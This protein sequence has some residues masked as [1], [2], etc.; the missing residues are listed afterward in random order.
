MEN[1][2]LTALRR[3]DMVRPGDTVICAVSGG[4]DSMA[5]LWGMWLLKEKLGITVEAAHFNHNLRGEESR[6]DAE[7]VRS[8]CDFHEI[9]L[10]MGSG[11]VIPGPKGLE[12]AARDARYAFLRSLDGII[13]TAHT[14]DDNAETVLMHLLRGTGLRG[15]GGVTPKQGTLI[16][17]MLD[18]TRAEVEAFLNENYIRHVE[19]SSNG[20]DA[21][22]R[23]RL[24]HHVMP[25][26]KA[27][28]PSIATGLSAAAQR[29]REDALLLDE[30]ASE[31]D[32]TDVNALRA[33]PAP[34]RRRAIENL[35]KK[36]GFPEPSAGHIAQAEGVVFS[37]NP[38][39]RT[40]FGGLTLRRSY[41]KL[42]VDREQTVLQTRVL[43]REGVTAL[44]E[45]G[46]AVKTAVADGPGE[47]VVSPEG[48][49]VVRG[50]RPGDALTTKGGTKSLKKRFIDRKIPQWE[51]LAVPVVAD[52][53][54]VLA[55]MGF[56]VDET[57]R[58][59]GSYVRIEFVDI[60]ETAEE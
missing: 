31:L 39:A 7:F 29:I 4:V 48:E 52:S 35:L 43:P 44:P 30:L 53:R 59:G 19:D 26:L 21:F 32:A 2:L 25:L 8:F 18:V 56:G 47:N 6:R 50:R 16:R 13:A 10:H 14:A 9:P 27:E 49:M 38:S 45:I 5:L 55:V 11:E 51:R 3:Y 36:N 42:C 54:G 22:L 12:A 23:N 17:P 24:R 20:G 37:D 1:K 41:E 28:N 34:L 33:A 57:R 40:S 15:L 46:A 60:S 58:T